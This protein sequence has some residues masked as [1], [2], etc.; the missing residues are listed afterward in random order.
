[1]MSASIPYE[2]QKVL[3]NNV[4]IAQ[5]PK[6][7]EVILIGKGIGFGKKTGDELKETGFDKVFILADEEEQKKYKQLLSKE[8]EEILLMI[9]EAI[10]KIHEW[11]GVEL[12]ERIH[13]ALTQHLVLAIQRTKDGTEIQNPF[14]TETKW[15]Y[16]D[17]YNIAKE[18]VELIYDKTGVKLPEAEVGFITLH[19]QSAIGERPYSPFNKK[20]DLIARTISYAEEKL[21]S[22]LNKESIY[23][24]R[25]IHHLK[26]LIDR[27]IES[28]LPFE[29]KM[30]EVLKDESELC[31]NVARNMV[32]MIEK[33]TQQQ[34]SQIETMY[35][36]LFLHRLNKN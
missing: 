8:E 9:H 33:A 30:I 13:Y 28:E 11:T 29:K 23:F 27:S 18:V 22:P 32:R 10:E 19:V 6:N 24:Q 1:M 5:T 31:Y 20:S 3:N 4:V 12:H 15:L 2:V 35:I 16:L 36:T 17:T 14:L 7:N 34:I 26:A 21:E 25:L